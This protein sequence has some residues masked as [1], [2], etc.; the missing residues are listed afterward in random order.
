MILIYFLTGIIVILLI[1]AGTMMYRENMRKQML[2]VLIN[3]ARSHIQQ[4]TSQST[5]NQIFDLYGNALT[6]L[7]QAQKSARTEQEILRVLN[8]KKDLIDKRDKSIIRLN[9][10]RVSELVSKLNSESSAESQLEYLIQARKIVKEGLIENA[11][12][13]LDRINHRIIDLFLP[14]ANKLAAEFLIAGRKYEALKIYERA[15]WQIFNTGIADDEL[16][17]IEDIANAVKQ[18]EKIERELNESYSHEA[19]SG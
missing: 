12:Q 15:L 2:R 19:E 16:D 1:I 5:I 3:L 10:L 17:Q 14:E 6:T 4:V 9:T 7:E 18:I 13:V 11:D 8:Y